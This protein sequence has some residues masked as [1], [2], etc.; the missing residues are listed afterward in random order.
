MIE[1]QAN[2]YSSESAQ[3]ELSNEYQHYKV[4][5]IFKDLCILVLWT[6]VAS[7]LEG[8]KQSPIIQNEP[9]TQKSTGNPIPIPVCSAQNCCL[10]SLLISLQ[11]KKFAKNI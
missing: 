8:L 2:G 1:T 4:P 5:M 9:P 11:Q 7:A 3:G 10:T 6:K